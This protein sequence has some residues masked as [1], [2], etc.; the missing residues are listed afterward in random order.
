MND[1]LFC[2]KRKPE[3]PKIVVLGDLI[4]DRYTWGNA[5]R[6]SPEAPVMVLKTDQREARLGGAAS[7]A[8]LLLDLEMRVSL[9]GVV[10]ND[11][12]GRVLQKLLDEAGI[13]SHSV[14]IDFLRPTTTKERFIGRAAGRH[15]HQMLRVDDESTEPICHELE[16][17]LIQEVTQQLADCEVLLISDYAK[18]VCTPRLLRQVI[19]LAHDQQIPVLI[20]PASVD[21]FSRYRGADLL[22]PNRLETSRVTRQTV[23]TPEAALD[24]ATQLCKNLDIPHVLVTLDSQGMVLVGRNGEKKTFATQKRSVYDITGAGDTVL[25]TL[26]FGQATG[27]TLDETIDLA[28]KAAGLQIERLGVAGISRHKLLTEHQSE[29]TDTDDK[30]VTLDQMAKL[31][32]NYRLSGKKVIFTNGCFDLLHIGHVTY[33]QQAAQLGEVL[34]VAVNSDASVSKLKGP[35]RPVIGERN[36]AT[37]LSALACVDH[38]IIFD[39]STPH[40]LLREIRPT[41]LVKGGTYRMDEVVGKD[42]VHGYG[43]EVRI[44]GQ[45]DGVSTTDI[46]ASVKG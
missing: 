32:A 29:T 22:K 11:T 44:T 15:P 39:E 38:V 13:D 28:N 8:A 4:L 6:V 1:V 27:L 37:L 30:L 14:L 10:G 19:D 16:S 2:E 43:G 18:G 45:I 21:D 34:I 36:R 9:I 26:G 46:L 31:A 40:K 7:V 23:E 35:D 41:V 12:N 17:T 33:L 42:V 25:A 3:N 5:E 24:A 20:D